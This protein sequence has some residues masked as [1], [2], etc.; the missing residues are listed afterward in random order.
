[1][2]NHL[3]GPES[4]ICPICGSLMCLHRVPALKALDTIECFFRC[5]A[6]DYVSGELLDIA[7][8]S[9]CNI[10]RSSIGGP[11]GP[12]FIAQCEHKISNLMQ[13]MRAEV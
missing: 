1:M 5:D 13:G 4:C 2:H 9:V 11:K 8:G 6:C 7:A 10:R 12:D 3:L